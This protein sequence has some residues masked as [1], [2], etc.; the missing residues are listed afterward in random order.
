MEIAVA[1]TAGALETK[2]DDVLGDGRAMRTMLAR[3]VAMYLAAVGFGMSYSR[4]GAAMGRD[5][6][7]VAYACRQVE[8]RRELQD[9]DRWLD[10]LEQSIACVPGVA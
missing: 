9:F 3:Q 1:M 8:G 4:V 7:T 5:R 2:V 6:S 10:A